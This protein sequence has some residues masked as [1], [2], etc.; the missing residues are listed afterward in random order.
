MNTK[1]SYD[2]QVLF[3][4]KNFILP[5]KISRTLKFV[6]GN[7]SQIAQLYHHLSRTL[8]CVVRKRDRETRTTVVVMFIFEIGYLHGIIAKFGSSNRR[9]F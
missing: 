2:M 7:K 3:C 6:S 4:H 9:I 5:P 8:K 1:L